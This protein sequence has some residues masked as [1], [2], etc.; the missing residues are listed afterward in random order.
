MKKSFDDL[1]RMLTAAENTR[2]KLS[3]EINELTRQKSECHAEAQAA[4]EA[5]DVDSYMEKHKAEERIDAQ[6][7]VKRTQM[8]RIS[9]T[10][11]REDVMSAWA[12]YSKR[13]DSEFEKVWADYLKSR[14]ASY[15]LFMKVCRLQNDALKTRERCACLAGEDNASLFRMKT[16]DGKAAEGL[17]YKQ[18]ML[19]MP[20]TCFFLAIGEATGEDGALFN[21]VIR[22]QK[23]YRP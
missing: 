14:T 20:D 17:R 11:S 22:V 23:P 1:E 4:A 7:F 16:I 18:L 2:Q 10:A 21:D 19:Q 5:G 9:T 6:I 8:D 15:N 13:Y 12:D 3:E